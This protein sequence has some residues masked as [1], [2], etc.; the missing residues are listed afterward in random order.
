MKRS[1][2]FYLHKVYQILDSGKGLKQAQEELDFTKQKLN[3]YVNPLKKLG[4][5]EKVGYGSWEVKKKWDQKEVDIFLKEVKKTTRIGINQ[6][7][8]VKNLKEVRGHAV[9]IK[10]I[11][12]K[13]YN[14][15]ENR[16]KIF[17]YVGLDF[18][19]H[20]IGGIVRGE[21]AIFEGTKIHFYNKSIDFNFDQRSFLEE[22]AKK[23]RSYALVEFLRLV[24]KLE[25][26]FNNSP[27]S[28]FG[29]Y[30]F[31]I[32]RQH[33]AI[34]KNAL[35]KQ[36][37]NEKKKLECYTAKGLWLLIDN[38]FNLEELETVHP[39]TSP[40]DN[41]KVQ[42]VFNEIKKADKETLKETAP[43]IIKEKFDRQ[44]NI[45]KKSMN[46]L[47]GYAEQIALHLEVEKEQLKTQKETQKILKKIG[48]KIK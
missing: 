1:K 36:Y 43:I 48:E 11:L 20:K 26:M 9:Q 21:K 39:K 14:N 27:L 40:E 18:E 6:L 15:W 5:I 23:S 17:K 42:L 12:P 24:K 47:E 22:T 10:L 31:K 29:K 2:N 16:R 35:A 38:S 33:Y 13:N 25:R 8:E 34:I 37:I 3:Y 28:D 44:E 4:Y 7:E 45:I 30:K 19:D 46:V 41:E 32:T